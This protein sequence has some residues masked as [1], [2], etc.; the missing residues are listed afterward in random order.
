MN[1]FESFL[2]NKHIVENPMLL[3]DD[4]PDAFDAWLGELQA[5][6]FIKYGEEFGEMKYEVGIKDEHFRLKK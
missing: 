2:Q 3:D 5:D 1:K 4:L 6:D